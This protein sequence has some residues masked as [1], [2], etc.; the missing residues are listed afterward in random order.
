VPDFARTRTIIERAIDAHAFPG[1]V[2]EVGTPGAVSW[3]E[4]LGH[5][6]YAPDAGPV[7]GDTVFDLASLT[8]VVATTTRAMSLVDEGRLSLSDRLAAFLPEWSGLR[9]DHLA[10]ARAQCGLPR[11]CRCPHA[12]AA[13]NS[14]GPSAGCH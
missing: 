6:T 4:A 2:I 3:T 9:R 8:K 7:R 1:A 13:T 10:P 5:L 14:S 12:P 11:G